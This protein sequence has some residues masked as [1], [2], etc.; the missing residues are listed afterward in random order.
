MIC[1]FHLFTS[2]PLLLSMIRV[3]REHLEA[4]RRHGEETYPEECCGFL[5]GDKDGDTNVLRIVHRAANEWAK[6]DGRESKAN[7]YLITPQQAMRAEKLAREHK[8]GVI[9]YYHSHPDHPAE[10]S[11]FDLDHSCWPTDSYIIVAV[12]RG[13][14]AALNSFTKPDYE[15]F[16]PEE[17]V[18][19]D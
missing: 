19:E 3:K 9:G 18:L 5:I 12:E 6:E 1:I 10:P 7:R 16:E 17:I 4:I 8:L 13:K 14:A 2:S 15:S 11:G